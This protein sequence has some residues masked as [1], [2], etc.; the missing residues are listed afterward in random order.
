MKKR[1]L[2]INRIFLLIFILAA[3]MVLPGCRTRI[4]NNTQVE[5][6]VYDDSGYLGELYDERRDELSLSVAEKPIVNLRKADTDSEG[7]YDDTDTDD[8]DDFGDDETEDWEDEDESDDTTDTTPTAT[9]PTTTTPTSPGTGTS[10]TPTTTPV[11]PLVRVTLDPNGGKTT[12]TL[13]NVRK[14]SL[15]GTLPTATRD[16]YTFK[17]WYT[18]KKGGKQVTASTKVTNGSAHT[19]YAH[20]DK[21]EKKTYKVSFDANAGDDEYELSDDSIK[22]EENGTYGT[23]PTAKREGYSFEGWY[24]AKKGGKQVK[25]GDKFTANENLTLYAHWKFDPYLTWSN[26]FKEQ[27]NSIADDAVVYCDTD[28]DRKQA[29]IEE[30]RGIIDNDDESPV[31]VIVFLKDFS[32]EEAEAAAEAQK[33]TFPESTVVVVSSDAV[34]GND[35]QQLL[36]KLMLL[37]AMYGAI[38][39]EEINKAMTDLDAEGDYPYVS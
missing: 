3:V 20:W 4:S 22:V 31:Y 13:M 27:A 17:G 39:E 14:D 5:P 1:A 19:L 9:T 36:Y 11:Q 10:T 15:Y 37:D 28:D 35:N 24:T 34:K 29:L 21:I 38:G 25:K 12:S 6:T 2:S 30:C 32:E 7:D 8:F 33:E 23:L 16:G 26:T 18:K